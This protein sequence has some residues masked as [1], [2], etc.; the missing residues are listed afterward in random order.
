[1]LPVGAEAWSVPATDLAS[2]RQN[3]EIWRRGYMPRANSSNFGAS[4]RT[5]ALA[6]QRWAKFSNLA[7]ELRTAGRIFN[8]CALTRENFSKFL[9]NFALRVQMRAYGGEWRWKLKVSS[10]FAPVSSRAPKL[11][12]QNPSYYN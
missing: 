1:M 4:A 3:F 12:K 9:E 8:F 11:T 2:G 5:D 10:S 6:V 7:A